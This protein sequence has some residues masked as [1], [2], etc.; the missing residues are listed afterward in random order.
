MDTT[1]PRIFWNRISANNTELTVVFD[2]ADSGT[3]IVDGISRQF[4]G[5]T[6][7]HPNPLSDGTHTVAYSKVEN[8]VTYV[9]PYQVT[10][11]LTA[12]PSLPMGSVVPLKN[13]VIVTQEHP[14]WDYVLPYYRELGTTSWQ[15]WSKQYGT[16]FDMPVLKANTN[17]E[18]RLQGL[19]KWWPI[20]SEYSFITFKTTM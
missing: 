13:S 15:Y 14:T 17:Y 4:T 11:T 5:T 19:N 9:Y 16:I 3:V 10:R 6:Y 1:V 18:L 7:T 2:V 20:G 8:G 12:K